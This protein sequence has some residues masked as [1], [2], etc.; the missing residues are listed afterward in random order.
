MVET[1][2]GSTPE[3]PHMN[4]LPGRFG[5]ADAPLTD[6]LDPHRSLS[7][8]APRVSA[9]ESSLLECPVDHL[10]DLDVLASRWCCCEEL[11]LK[12]LDASC[13]DS[14]AW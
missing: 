8:H 1:P 14:A 6:S 13:V 9:A 4:R 7:S 10:G 11:S 2:V 5:P 3:E 12:R